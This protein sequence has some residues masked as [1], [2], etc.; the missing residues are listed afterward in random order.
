MSAILGDS[1]AANRQPAR[2]PASPF[3]PTSKPTS[4]KSLSALPGDTSKAQMNA[5]TTAKTM[6]ELMGS[7]KG[8]KRAYSV[9]GVA[10]AGG[11]R[12]LSPRSQARR[13]AV[14][15]IIPQTFN[16]IDSRSYRNRENQSSRPPMPLPSS[17]PNGN[18]LSRPAFSRPDLQDPRSVLRHTHT[19]STLL[20]PP[21]QTN[22]AFHQTKKISLSDPKV[23]V[24]S[25]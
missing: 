4:R 20:V 17:P 15:L 3:K 9:G 22:Q 10:N 25:T 23:V 18:H 6:E 7:E 5:D 21:S 11:K 2:T 19:R 14:S 1:S 13:T 16:R 8:R 12:D 24:P